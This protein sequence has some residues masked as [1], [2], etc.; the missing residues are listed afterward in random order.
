MS[1]RRLTPVFD[2]SGKPELVKGFCA[3]TECEHGEYVRYADYAAQRAQL[4]AA[5][6]RITRMQDAL[7]S[8]AN[9]AF[10]ACLHGGM[11]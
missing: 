11:P 3:M 8:L 4:E 10:H 6:A 9:T 7:R 1:V 5:Q 2:A